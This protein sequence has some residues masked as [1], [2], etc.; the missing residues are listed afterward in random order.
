MM[1]CTPFCC[2]SF[3]LTN[4]SVERSKAN[5]D[6]ERSKDHA[7]GRQ[8]LIILNLDQSQESMGD[9]NICSICF[10]SYNVGPTA[11]DPTD[12]RPVLTPNCC[13]HTLCMQCAE[14]HRAAKV[15]ELSGN[16][17]KIP[18]PK[19]NVPFHSE[20]GRF[21]VNRDKL[22]HLEKMG[23]GSSAS[24][25]AAS[26]DAAKRRRAQWAVFLLPP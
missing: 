1:I 17:K 8:Q 9:E 25:A 13:G 22:T 7:G 24:A 16:R 10:E 14:S 20:N 2:S 4:T 18:C 12:R 19:C 5:N 3:R 21:V 23:A 26:S 11:E 6:M 15:A